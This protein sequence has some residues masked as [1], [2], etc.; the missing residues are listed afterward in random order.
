M[1]Y[2][3]MPFLHNGQNT[4]GV[5]YYGVAIQGWGANRV[6]RFYG[7]GRITTPKGDVA[8]T[9]DLNQDWSEN[10]NQNGWVRYPNGFYLQWGIVP[11]TNGNFKYPIEFP[12]AALN[13]VAGN[14]NSQGDRVDNT[15][16]NLV[17]KA[18]FFCA[19]KS[20][21]GAGW[22]GYPSSW[23]AVGW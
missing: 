18:T 2:T 5:P 10:F 22:T 8:F 1:S 21:T 19:N 17:D 13:I 12:N 16:A 7:D 3:Y 15:W 11:V 6:L 4:G 20:S 14:I 9:S 23:M